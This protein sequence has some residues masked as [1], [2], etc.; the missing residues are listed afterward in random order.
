MK[1]SVNC[2]IYNSVYFVLQ[3]VLGATLDVLVW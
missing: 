1:I 2:N 3:E